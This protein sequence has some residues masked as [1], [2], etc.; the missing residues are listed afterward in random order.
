MIRSCLA[1]D[2]LEATVSFLSSVKIPYNLGAELRALD[3]QPGKAVFISWEDSASIDGW[4]KDPKPDVGVISSVGW[5]VNSNSKAVVISTSLNDQFSCICPL[6]I[7]WSS[8]TECV[9][10]PR[11]DWGRSNYSN[12]ET[13]A[14]YTIDLEDRRLTEEYEEICEA[15]TAKIKAEVIND[16]VL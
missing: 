3:L 12:D 11:L 8:I 2:S 15:I 10:I 1:R 4:R 14:V 5:V 7:P 13:E 9:E 6:S 16:P